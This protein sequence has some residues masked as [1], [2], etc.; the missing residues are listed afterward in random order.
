MFLEKEEL[1]S[2]TGRAFKSL[3]IAWLRSSGIPFRVNATGHPVVTRAAVEGKVEPEIR[4]AVWVSKALRS[5]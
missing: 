2:L 5:Q 4:Q 1:R 3:Q